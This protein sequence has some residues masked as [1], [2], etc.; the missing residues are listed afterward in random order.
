MICEDLSRF[1]V[2]VDGPVEEPDGV[3]CGAFLEDFGCGYESGVVVEDCDQPCG[4]YEFEV[5]LP[6][7]VRMS[8]LPASVGSFQSRLLEGSIQS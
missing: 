5:A 6:E 7:A 4:V 2:F 8:A 3:L 1:R